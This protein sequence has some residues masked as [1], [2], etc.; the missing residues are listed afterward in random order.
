MLILDK[1]KAV[2]RIVELT[3]PGGREEP[4]VTPS[5]VRARGRTGPGRTSFPRAQVLHPQR[6]FGGPRRPSPVAAQAS[7]RTVALPLGEVEQVLTHASGREL[8][9]GPVEV[10]S[11]EEPAR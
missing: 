9:F 3:S 7:R 2:H 1:Q 8:R 11:G 4:P 5:G 6:P 10:L